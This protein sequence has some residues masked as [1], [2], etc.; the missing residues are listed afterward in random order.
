V[1]LHLAVAA[2]ANDESTKLLDLLVLL[3]VTSQHRQTIFV[4]LCWVLYLV[5]AIIRFILVTL[6]DLLTE[7]TVFDC[8]RRLLG[9]DFFDVDAWVHT[10]SLSLK[11]ICLYF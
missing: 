10:I 6:E 11:W 5:S 8:S 9:K 4:E 1:F 3:S 2:L 7:I